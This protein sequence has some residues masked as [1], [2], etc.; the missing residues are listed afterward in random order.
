MICSWRCNLL[1]PSFLMTHSLFQGEVRDEKVEES[2]FDSSNESDLML[3][4]II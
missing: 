3:N 4:N 2:D 1:V